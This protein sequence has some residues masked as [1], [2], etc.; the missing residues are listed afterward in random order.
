MI[1]YQN[2][3]NFYR[4]LFKVFQLRDQQMMIYQVKDLN[5]NHIVLLPISCQLMKMIIILK[6]SINLLI[7]S[8][9]IV[10]KQIIRKNNGL[11]MI[12]ITKMLIKIN[13]INNYLQIIQTFHHMISSL[14][15]YRITYPKQIM[16]PTYKQ[17]KNF[18]KCYKT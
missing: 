16:N 15:D 5:I 4:T 12:I 1:L 3:C 18:N 11:K 14:I 17:K 9:Q 2:M 10:E 8:Y 7:F 6:Y 13:R